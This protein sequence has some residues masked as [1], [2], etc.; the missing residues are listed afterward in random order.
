MQFSTIIKSNWSVLSAAEKK[1]REWERERVYCDSTPGWFVE[2][3]KE[4]ED[5]KTMC[6]SKWNDI[7][8][9]WWQHSDDNWQHWVLPAM[10]LLRFFS[11]SPKV[12]ICLFIAWTI[13]LHLTSLPRKCF[14]LKNKLSSNLLYW[15]FKIIVNF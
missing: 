4:G 12:W 10:C 14:Q 8:F 6:L 5:Y 3:M 13:L 2:L 1:E 11:L 15:Y 9:L 7:L